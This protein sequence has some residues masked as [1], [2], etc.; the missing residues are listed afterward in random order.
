MQPLKRAPS[1]YMLNGVGL[2]P[3]GRRAFDPDTG[4]YIVTICLCVCFIPVLCLRPTVS[5]IIRR[6]PAP[7]TVRTDFAYWSKAGT[8]LDFYGRVSLSILAKAWNVLLP[9]L[10]AGAYGC[11]LWA[12]S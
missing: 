3:L 7:N 4:T 10:T 5:L 1:M 11:V 12:V 6:F 8:N 9:L 2:W